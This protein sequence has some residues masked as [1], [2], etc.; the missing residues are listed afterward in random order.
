MI[1]FL[2]N[3]HEGI[4]KFFQGDDSCIPVSEFMYLHTRPLLRPNFLTEIND[5]VEKVGQKI[6]AIKLS[7]KPIE[8]LESMAIKLGGLMD[9]EMTEDK[10]KATLLTLRDLHKLCTEL[11]KKL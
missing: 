4:Q 3:E 5:L 2:L 8:S 7:G 10:A 11:D 6:I 1:S 9:G